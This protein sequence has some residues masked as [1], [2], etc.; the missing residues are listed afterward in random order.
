MKYKNEG[1]ARYGV[2]RTEFVKN[3]KKIIAAQDVCAICGLPVDKKLKAPHPMSATVDHIIPVAKGGHPSDIN[4]MQLAHFV[5]NRMKSDHLPTGMVE[6]QK[7]KE[8][9]GNRVLPL[10]IDWE[11]YK[12]R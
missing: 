3:R 4:N 2:H 1:M 5:C 8:V 6:L 11:T 10:I 9:I 7:K 12:A